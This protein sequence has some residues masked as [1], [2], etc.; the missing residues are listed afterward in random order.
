[1]SDTISMRLEEEEAGL[2]L[3]V[4]ARMTYEGSDPHAVRAQFV[5]GET[6]LAQWY[7]DRQMLADGLRRPVGEGDVSLRPQRDGA[8]SAVR[9][10]LRGDPSSG[11]GRA[12]L[13]ADAGAVSRFLEQTYAMV[14]AGEENQDV[15]GFLAEVFAAE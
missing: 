6:F 14:A 12:V 1:M 8:H 2:P 15:D 3:V 7:L 4:E 11:Q 9:F 13:L 5:Y 10:E